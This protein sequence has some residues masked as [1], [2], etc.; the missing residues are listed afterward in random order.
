MQFLDEAKI[1][2]A[3]GHGGAGAVSFRRE[4]FIPR[5]GPDGG[6]GGHGGHVI[7]RAVSGLNTLVDYRYQGH[8]KAARGES[9]KSKKRTGGQGKDAILKVPLGTQIF[10]EEHMLADLTVENQE[11]V[12][13]EG[14]QGGRGNARF[15]SSTVQAPR[16]AQKGGEGKQ[17]AVVLRLKIIADVGIVGLPN[18][19]KSTLLSTVSRARPAIANYPFTTRVPH[20][21]V[22]ESGQTAFVMADIPGLIEKAHLGVGLGHRFLA[23]VERCAFLLHL[24]DATSQNCVKNYKTLQKELACYSK[25]LA[26]KP[27]MVALSKVDALT[28]DKISKCV[29]AL[30]PHV[31]DGQL[32]TV[33]CVSGAGV[34]SLLH[35]LGRKVD[36]AKARHATE[37]ASSLKGVLS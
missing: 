27:Q 21:G 37:E 28:P 1:I 11:V 6:D 2:I 13:L 4:K 5:G 15:T 32:V 33:S 25:A 31:R 17:C 34:Q 30:T 9:G 26:Q 22:V 10:L 29:A 20:L 8:F 23:H 35:L 7:A 16:Y 19:G 24:V 3:S 12:L 18:A 36:E 14:G